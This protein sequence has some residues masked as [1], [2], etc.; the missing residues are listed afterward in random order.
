MATFHR[1]VDLR[2]EARS[3]SKVR[4]N[5]RG[6]TLVE[7]MM[8]SAVMSLLAA[9]L[10]ALAS[11]V[12]VSNQ[13]QLGRG[14]SIQHGQVA[15]GRIE[16]ALRV[17]TANEFFPGFI[18]VSETV[19]G[20]TFPD[21][22]IVWKPDGTP[23]NEDGLPLVSELVVFTPA[24][25]SPN[26]LLELR[27]PYDTSEVPAVSATRDW[28]DLVTNLKSSADYEGDSNAVVLTDLMRVAEVTSST[29]RSIATRGCVR[30]EQSL[31]PSDA[32][33]RSYKAGS[34]TWESLPWVQGIY[35]ATSGQ[36]QSLCRIE[37][38]LRP[39][40]LQLNDKQIAIPFLSSAAIYYQLER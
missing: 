40:D 17:A 16:H 5:R 7:L 31:R 37:L 20:S 8:V 35:G 26:R 30:F 15:I 27:D 13:Q 3:A 32:E 14:L 23:V 34:A 19:N 1:S 25:G 9:T 2:A 33:W 11:T 21:T 38:Q 6:M 12:Q 18:V 10:A 4:P 29:T 22:L 24:D 36:R 28:L 39:A